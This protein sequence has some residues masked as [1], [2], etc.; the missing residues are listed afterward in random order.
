[1][2]PAW[3]LPLLLLCQKGVAHRQ[4]VDRIPNG[5]AFRPVWKAVGHVAPLPQAIKTAKGML[6]ANVRFPRN[7]FG[8]DFA[9]AGFV[10][11]EE[12]CRADSD[13][14]GKSNGQELG[15]PDCTWRFQRGRPSAAPARTN[16]TE[17]SHPGIPG[18]AG[19]Y[20]HLVREAAALDCRVG[21]GCQKF[22]SGPEVPTGKMKSRYLAPAAEVAYYHYGVVPILL[23]LGVLLTA[24]SPS[25]PRPRWQIV[26]LLAYLVC[27]VGV[28]IGCHRYAAHHAFVATPVLKWI[29]SFFAAWC[30]QGTPA[31]WAFLHRLHHRFCDQ[32]DLDLQAPRA[33]HHLLYGHF[34]WFVEPVDHFY[35]SSI[36]NSEAIIPDLLHDERMPSFGKDVK[37]AV[38]CHLLTVAALALGYGA[39]ELRRRW[40]GGGEPL[41]R[42]AA[43]TTFRTFLICCWYFWLPC[44]LAF[45]CVLLVIDAVHMWGDLAFEDAMSAPCEAKNNAFLIIPLLGENWHNNHHSAPHSASNWIWAYHFDLQYLVIRF[46]EFIG[47]ASEVV[48]APPSKLRDGY[49][50]DGVLTSV[51]A[52]WILLAAVLTT[53][54]WSGSLLTRLHALGRDLEAS[55]VVRT[56]AK[57]AGYPAGGLPRFL[58]LPDR[59]LSSTARRRGDDLGSKPLLG[60]SSGLDDIEEE[61]DDESEEYSS[62]CQGAFR[63]SSTRVGI[64][65][66]YAR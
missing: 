17:L 29:L 48:V 19:W 36:S 5:E 50:A 63:R 10:W 38:T 26:L 57:R 15:D 3:L 1:M 62:R 47:L 14:D 12:L 25:A 7:T 13:G 9:R 46:F 20:V 8:R 6:V 55:H 64:R 60:W 32:G 56:W 23:L 16:M 22:G 41:A 2:W 51:L 27:H 11:N 34:S 40:C 18:E 54:W 37:A 43:Q 35:M 65:T 52:E 58:P 42:A 61:D 39:C 66:S 59:R 33:P 53:P 21:V 44:A 30:M 28:F 49:V 45:Q 4:Y 31:H 24:R